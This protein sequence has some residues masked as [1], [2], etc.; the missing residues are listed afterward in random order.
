[1]LQPLAEKLEFDGQHVA[2]GLLFS[3]VLLDSFCNLT[4]SGE[5]IYY[6]L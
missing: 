4:T 3:N 5:V 1:M 6:I 2:R